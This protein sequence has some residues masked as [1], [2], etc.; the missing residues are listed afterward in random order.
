[1][2][3]SSSSSTLPGTQAQRAPSSTGASGNGKDPTSP[4]HSDDDHGPVYV[5]SLTFDIEKRPSLSGRSESCA[6]KI[7]PSLP[8]TAKTSLHD[9]EG[10]LQGEV[11][12]EEIDAYP[13]GGLEVRV[14]LVPLRTV[15]G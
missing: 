3:Q 13:D 6:T 14:V 2:V 9:E 7:A 15:P 11:G 1:M 10:R 8:A 12:Q 4:S 5:Q